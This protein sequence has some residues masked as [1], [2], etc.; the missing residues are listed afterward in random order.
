MLMLS[1]NKQSNEH[2]KILGILNARSGREFASLTPYS[3]TDC[4]HSPQAPLSG[5]DHLLR[6]ML[7]TQSETVWF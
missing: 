2:K 1:S 7:S 5:E 4:L 3:V 6:G